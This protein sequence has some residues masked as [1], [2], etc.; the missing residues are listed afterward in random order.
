MPSGAIRMVVCGS[1]SPEAGYTDNICRYIYQGNREWMPRRLC[2]TWAK[3]IRTC[4]QVGDRP[5][6]PGELVFGQLLPVPTRS[7]T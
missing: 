6:L 5:H 4:R 1:A 3:T 7:V 2:A